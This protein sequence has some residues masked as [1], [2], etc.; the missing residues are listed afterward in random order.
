MDTVTATKLNHY[1]NKVLAKRSNAANAL[2]G[3]NCV[4]DGNDVY[5]T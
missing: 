2:F 4:A 1:A 3:G 5:G